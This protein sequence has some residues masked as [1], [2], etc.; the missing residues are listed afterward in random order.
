MLMAPPIGMPRF[1]LPS[2][3]AGLVAVVLM[4]YS[5]VIGNDQLFLVVTIILVSVVIVQWMRMLRKKPR[6]EYS[7]SHVCAYFC[8][9][10]L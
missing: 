10:D 3:L 8:T 5:I 1:D 4:A 2:L 9:H 6:I 7:S